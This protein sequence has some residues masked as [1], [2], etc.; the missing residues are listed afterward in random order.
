MELSRG[1]DGQGAAEGQRES[2]VTEKK[3]PGRTL[4]DISHYFITEKPAAPAIQNLEELHADTLQHLFLLGSH[5]LEA[6]SIVAC[7]LACAWSA[8]A[9]P[10]EVVE[11]ETKIPNS[12]FLM[13]SLIPENGG[14]P[15]NGSRLLARIDGGHAVELSSWQSRVDGNPAPGKKVIWNGPLE[16]ILK[17]VKKPETQPQILVLLE[18]EKRKLMETY[19]ELRQV[20][21][22][23]PDARWSA[24]IYSR[25]AAAGSAQNLFSFFQGMVQKHL[26][27]S[28][29][30][31]GELGMD[32]VLARSILARIPAVLS[33]EE[34][35]A[36]LKLRELAKQLSS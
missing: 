1:S 32:P 17:E 14:G 31:F 21:Q 4:A 13:G 25:G 27:L 3:K 10:V 11:G 12:H 9:V 26:Q 28:L 6:R 5:S 36:V 15:H 29:E 18:P 22:A 35:P 8:R 7:N 19:L 16:E 33:S 30:D 23:R 20:A 24:L 2:G 34:S